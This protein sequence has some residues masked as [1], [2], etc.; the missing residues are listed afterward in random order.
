MESAKSANAPVFSDQAKFIEPAGKQ[1]VS[2]QGRS[3]KP[4]NVSNNASLA[5]GSTSVSRIL[6]HEYHVSQLKDVKAATCELPDE[7]PD[8]F[9]PYRKSVF[10][11]LCKINNQFV[12]GGVSL[13]NTIN[14]FSPRYNDMIVALMK[15][16]KAS[17]AG[18]FDDEQK[19]AITGWLDDVFEL[20]PVG[21]RELPLV[22]SPEVAKWKLREEDKELKPVLEANYDEY[23][24]KIGRKAF[25]PPWMNRDVNEQDL[26]SVYFAYYNIRNE[27]VA[28]DESGASL[29]AAGLYD[30]DEALYDWLVAF[31]D[32]ENTRRVSGLTELEYNSVKHRLSTVDKGIARIEELKPENKFKW[33]Y[34]QPQENNDE[35]SCSGQLDD[36]ASIA[37]EEVP[38]VI[39]EAMPETELADGK[40]IK[41]SGSI[42]VTKARKGRKKRKACYETN[43]KGPGSKK[44]KTEVSEEYL[45]VKRSARLK[46]KLIQEDGSLV[47]LKEGEV[48]RYTYHTDPE[49]IKKLNLSSPL[50]KKSRVDRK[51][52]VREIVDI[53]SPVQVKNTLEDPLAEPVLNMSSGY[54]SKLFGVGLYEVTL[55]AEVVRQLGM[56]CDQEGEAQVNVDAYRVVTL[57]LEQ[58][59]AF[60]SESVGK[61]SESVEEDGN[62]LLKSLDPCFG[63]LAESVERHLYKKD[64]TVRPEIQ[65][66]LEELSLLRHSA[67]SSVREIVTGNGRKPS[68][69]YSVTDLF[70]S[71]AF[72]PSSRFRAGLLQ[73]EEAA[74]MAD[75]EVDDLPH[76]QYMSLPA[77]VSE[78]FPEQFSGVKNSPGREGYIQADFRVVGRLLADRIKHFQRVFQD[79]QGVWSIDDA[80]QQFDLI[81]VL[82]D[83]LNEYCAGRLR[84]HDSNRNLLS[85]DA[86]EVSGELMA[87]KHYYAICTL[88]P[89][90]KALADSLGTNNHTFFARE[91]QHKRKDVRESLKAMASSKK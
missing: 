31:Q 83:S 5:E 51:S 18:A 28:C 63:A 26:G 50:C 20:F 52:A 8:W 40:S 3:M 86:G 87:V 10:E 73:P 57:L 82:S 70:W 80:R 60:A 79:P 54:I 88:L 2:Y 84:H 59:R 17:Q 24:N 85:Q 62:R 68:D 27:N 7:C 15:L 23:L 42:S 1:E 69:D 14:A 75:A 77:E 35:G 30:K 74:S 22:V 32:E 29:T 44:I 71:A 76:D 53:I 90:L 45:A 47:P 12:R 56:E 33:D 37:A 65:K 38:E 66:T 81:K 19:R 78:R 49:V 58:L 91:L 72:K 43:N 4:A 67:H 64:K 34:L 48:Y 55:P 61:R 46:E 11:P 9:E 16:E 89:H 41:P 21:W 25:V 13:F 39:S 6:L 36:G